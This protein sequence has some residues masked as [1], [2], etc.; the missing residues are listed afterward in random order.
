[1]SPTN[2]R[3]MEHTFGV[4]CVDFVTRRTPDLQ[5]SSSELVVPTADPETRFP[6]MA[7]VG[8]IVCKLCRHP[9]SDLRLM[10]CGCCLHARCA[11]LSL[12]LDTQSQ[13]ISEY[14]DFPSPNMSKST[15]CPVCRS[16]VVEGI[17]LF[18]LS[19]K[20]LERAV[21]LRKLSPRNEMK[22]G[23]SSPGG[24]RKSRDDES[25]DVCAE[26]SYLFLCS[27]RSSFASNAI[28]DQR[29][30]RWTDEEIAFVDYLVSEFD[31]GTLPL[32]HGIKLHEFLGDML[33]C[34]S[35]RLTKKMKNAKLSTRSFVLTS[36]QVRSNSDATSSMSSLQEKF[37][38]SIHSEP[39]QLELRFNLSKQ[40]RIHFS[41]LCVQIGYPYLNG[42]DWASSLEELDRRAA[43]A[44][45]L[46]RS[47]RRKKMGMT[48]SDESANI[49]SDAL[50][51]HQSIIS[52]DT[53]QTAA[54][55]AEENGAA[56]Q[57][58]NG[59]GEGSETHSTGEDEMFAMLEGFDNND[60]TD[61]QQQK[62]ARA[63]TFS[64]DFLQPTSMKQRSFSEDFD[65][66]LN[67]LMDPES[68]VGTSTKTGG[69]KIQSVSSSGLFLEAI[70]TYMV[71]MNL[72]FQHADVWVPSFLPRDSNGPSKAVDMEQLRLFHA[73]F[74]TRNDIE[75]SAIA[76]L[77]EFGVYSDNFTFEPEQGLPGDVYSSGNIRWL[78]GVQ[79][80]TTKVFERSNGAKTHGIKTAVGIPLNTPLV[81]RIVVTLYSRDAV[82]EDLVMAK[83]CQAELMKYSPAPKWKLVIE[84]N[85]APRNLL[86]PKPSFGVQ[87]MVQ[88]PNL[89]SASQSG[90]N[91]HALPAQVVSCGSPNT[92]TASSP[93]AEEQRIVALLGEHMPLSDGSVGEPSTSAGAN[94]SLLSSFM[95]I[96]LMFLRSA[97]RRSTQ[98]NEMV[99]VLKNSYR[100]YAKDNRRSGAE[101]ANLLAKDWSCLKSTYDVSSIPSNN[102]SQPL[103]VNRRRSTTDIGMLK[104]P[105]P[106]GQQHSSYTAT[107]IAGPMNKPPAQFMPSPSQLGSALPRHSSLGSLPS[108]NN[109]GG[110]TSYRGQSSGFFQPQP[111]LSSRPPNPSKPFPNS[112]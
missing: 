7:T 112:G 109:N 44:E 6:T 43:M 107:P 41:N 85:D 98:E 82:P 50:S 52:M 20:D 12:V 100:A 11:P 92:P 29:T 42:K 45:E 47:N 8:N 66:V 87:G 101:L 70:T 104:A 17:Y 15:L 1:M 86:P 93:D 106:L 89:G 19:F 95:A 3:T 96:R 4:T 103:S 65:A 38:M 88:S 84:M 67:D 94:A 57:T 62:R 56:L 54:V 24:K 53:T 71:R 58:S 77:N 13:G 39:T 32:P 28:A 48:Q 30:G 59:D 23:L 110:N 37:L 105:A 74:S 40:W 108:N 55:V 99:D 22:L 75:S 16:S 83:A 33:L 91:I 14:G 111:V 63:R 79:N 73:G 26:A 27:T 60:D 81:G 5:L 10:G 72:P 97:A 68:A 76:A 36:S 46:I 102:S 21:E 49:E 18:P 64:E 25:P 69:T 61:G 34:K 31:K 9:G 51:S 80:F 2:F 35:S 90:G 78:S